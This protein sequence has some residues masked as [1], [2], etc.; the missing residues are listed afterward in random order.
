MSMSKSRGWAPGVLLAQVLVVGAL[1]VVPA[2]A[3]APSVIADVRAAIAAQDFARGDAVLSAYRTARGVTPE[4]LE[5]LSWMG[6]GSLAAGRLD[7]AEAYAR[8]TY[9]LCLDALDRRPMDAEPRV[10]IAIG[11]AIEV[12][13]NVRA[14]R[15]AVSDAVYFLTRELETYGRTSIATRIQKNINLL[16][17]EGKTA[18]A[19]DLSEFIGPAPTA[20]ADLK[21]K[22]A[23]LFF[24]AHWCP[25]C[26]AQS[27]SL[28]KLAAAYADQGLV[29]VAPTQRYGYVT[30][31]QTAAPDE[32]RRHIESVLG[33]Y[34]GFLVGQSIPMSP[35][36]HLRYGVSTTP[37]LVLV[38]RA[39]IVRLYHPGTLDDAELDARVRA[40]LA[41]PG[42]TAD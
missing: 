24:W 2:R 1:A 6:R 34:Y 33:T 38:D 19:L 35:Q 29:V 11:A 3:Q 23:V 36:N 40:L 20:L 32:E 17:L 10:P 28:A 8:E 27:P 14:R 22:V 21:G 26:K 30:R 13:A 39:G 42:G 15:G 41:A 18:P 4:F 7:E 12:Q 16:S 37:T 25:D 9:D 31:G 5:A